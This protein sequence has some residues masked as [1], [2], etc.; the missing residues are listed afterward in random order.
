MK[1]YSAIYW[2]VLVLLGA[3][4]LSGCPRETQG[5]NLP[6]I[7]EAGLEQEALIKTLVTLDGGRSYDPDGDKITYNWRFLVVPVGGHA[8]LLVPNGRNCHFTP[9][10]AGYWV[11]ELIVSDGDLLSEAD[12]VGV[13]V[14]KPQG[15]DLVLSD[16]SAVGLTNNNYVSNFSAQILNMGFKYTGVVDFR[17]IGLDQWTNPSLV[18]DK[19]VTLDNVSLDTGS[20][21]WFSLFQR[22]IEWPE[23]V[24]RALFIV[25]VDPINQIVE[26]NENNNDLN[27]TLFRDD[28]AGYCS[29]ENV[30][31]DNLRIINRGGEGLSFLVEE[32]Q[33][34][35]FG[36]WED[37]F[38][39]GLDFRNCCPEMTVELSIIY[40]WTPD[41][42]D[43]K[44]I[45]LV[46]RNF[47]TLEP[48]KENYFTY[49]TNNVPREERYEQHAV[50]L[51]IIAYYD[52]GYAVL[53]QTPVKS[54][55]EEII[56]K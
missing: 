51:A 12:V 52:G 55:Y 18:F 9:D 7:A 56:G 26:V 25:K 21:G 15:E 29:Y 17:V 11:I 31:T 27:K 1:Q 53:F 34:F 54:E 20:S 28:V 19:S 32:G 13:R 10:V 24:C 30:L 38:Q 49:T 40:D 44:N 35:L 3:L 39:F 41:P 16:I 47:V 4:L 48:G 22:E 45:V 2:I 33:E 8:T 23:D 36:F 6:P 43:G 37:P 5:P 46:D 42:E 50:T 14:R